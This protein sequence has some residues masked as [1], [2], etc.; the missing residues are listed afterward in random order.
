MSQSDILTHFYGFEESAR[1]LF[2]QTS[3]TFNYF[4]ITSEHLSS[5][6]TELSQ[7]RKLA[8]I[9][10]SAGNEVEIHMYFREQAS[11][12]ESTWLEALKGG[13]ISVSLQGFARQN[14]QPARFNYEVI[15]DLWAGVFGAENFF[16]HLYFPNPTFSIVD[17]FRNRVLG[18]AFVGDIETKDKRENVRLSAPKA[19][20]LRVSNMLLQSLRNRRLQERYRRRVLRGITD[21]PLQLGAPA[22]LDIETRKSIHLAYKQSNAVFFSKFRPG[23]IADFEGIFPEW[24]G[25]R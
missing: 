9:L 3:G 13:R 24:A 2:E 8:R 6:L 15:S 4:L 5:R 19:N 11:L 10:A 12:L 14:R 20:L 21:F 16:A 7:V 22:R 25:L 1:A 17:D 23:G 18:E